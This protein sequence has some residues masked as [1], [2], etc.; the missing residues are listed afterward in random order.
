MRIL[1]PLGNALAKWAKAGSVQCTVEFSGRV[2]TALMYVGI[3][4]SWM[5]KGGRYDDRTLAQRLE[6]GNY[7]WRAARRALFA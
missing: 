2:R 3:A 7:Y 6:A 4:L 5:G 1:S